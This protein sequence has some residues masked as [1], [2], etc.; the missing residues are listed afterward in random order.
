MKLLVKFE[1]MGPARYISHLDLQRCVQRTLRLMEAP[2]AYSMGFNPHPLL[3]FAQALSLFMESRGEYFMVELIEDMEIPVFL[4][5]FNLYGYD[6]IAA[7][8]ARELMEG[9]K[10]PMAR[11]AA[12]SYTYHLDGSMEGMKEAMEGFLREEEVWFEKKGKKGMKKENMRTRVFDI[13]LSAEGELTM[14]VGCG[15]VNLPPRE[16]VNALYER[17]GNEARVENWALMRT[18]LYYANEKGYVPFL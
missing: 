16:L 7:V 17:M 12:A 4:E 9:E 1:K 11:V 2:V 5:G 3:S 10:N 8:A 14:L 6:G 13:A 18:D 15:E